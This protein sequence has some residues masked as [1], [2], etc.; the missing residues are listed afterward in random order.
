M[1]TGLILSILC[2]LIL[3]GCTAPPENPSAVD[4]ASEKRAM[5]KAEFSKAMGFA[6]HGD[7]KVVLER[8]D[9][10]DQQNLNEKEKAAMEKAI[11]NFTSDASKRAP[12]DLDVWVAKVLT[13]Y[14]SYWVDVMMGRVTAQAAERAL[15]DKLAALVG[16]SGQGTSTLDT[17]EP[18]VQKEIETRGYYSLHGKTPPFR[19][20]MLWRKQDDRSY[21]VEL[22]EGTENVSVALL[23]D[24]ISLGWL[25]FATGDYYHSGGWATNE[26]LF[27][28][29][30]AYTLDSESFRVSYL[31]HE[32]QHFSDYKRFPKLDPFELEYRAKLVEIVQADTTIYTLLDAFNRNG[33]DD[34]DNPHGYANRMLLNKLA[35][36]LNVTDPANSWWTTLPKA[37]LQAAALDVLK[38]DSRLRSIKQ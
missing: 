7:M 19:E 24:F 26:R 6:F 5:A 29:S 38:E 14:E 21:K 31:G 11:A 13:A 12:A 30:K 35:A 37:K 1:K 18:L 8:F 34:R 9:T 33:S 20:F 27:C 16:A 23:D 25:G 32:A 2:T 36:A 17:I 28:V 15:A 10:I 4:V 3:I 22:P